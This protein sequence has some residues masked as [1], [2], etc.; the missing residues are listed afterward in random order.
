MSTVTE[1]RAHGHREKD[2]L[3]VQKDE[4]RILLEVLGSSKGYE[5]IAVEN[6][7]QVQ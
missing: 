3:L 4:Q 7:L 1:L 6:A 5:G 2:A